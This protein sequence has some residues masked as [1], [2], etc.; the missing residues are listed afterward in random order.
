MRLHSMV[1][2]NFAITIGPS[3]LT[4]LTIIDYNI[5][6]RA[7]LAKPYLTKIVGYQRAENFGS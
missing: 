4:A 1:T 5:P 3:T 6:A 7:R 2:V